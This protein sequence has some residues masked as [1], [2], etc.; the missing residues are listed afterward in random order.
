MGTRDDMKIKAHSD[1][2]GIDAGAKAGGRGS[3]ARWVRGPCNGGVI[4]QFGGF[5]CA[6]CVKVV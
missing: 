1:S 6:I 2:V 3:E 4:A 5:V